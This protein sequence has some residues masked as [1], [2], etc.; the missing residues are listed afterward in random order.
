MNSL[1]LHHYA[2]SPFSQK[3]RSMLGYTGIQWQ[4]VITREIPPRPLLETLTGGYR[5]IP[6]A[7]IGADIFCDTRTI[8]AEIAR[9]AGR[10]ELAL[11]NCPDDVQTY[12]AK[13][14]LKVFFACLTAGGT[15][16]LLR[17]VYKSMSLLDI[18]RFV[19]DRMRMGST[20]TTSM[21]PPQK[22][23]AYVLA[24]LTDIEQRLQSNFISGDAPNHADFSTYHSLWFVRDL[25]ESSLVN[26]FPRTMAWMDRMKGFGDGDHTALTAE[27][28]LVIAKNATPRPIADKYRT[29]PMIGHAVSIA[30]SDYGQV[31]TTGTLVGA[32]P[33]QWILARQVEGLGTLHVHFPRQGF[34]LAPA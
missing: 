29:D 10:P 20:A 24:H 21:V 27:Q 34:V 4:S 19:R 31:P 26:D 18:A 5:K 8:A 17:K 22:S 12:V 13:V 23:K 25:A 3:M 30:P 32:T 11:E 9:L 1:I 16:A 33:A 15:F 28:A 14:D 6:V 2:M 7:Q